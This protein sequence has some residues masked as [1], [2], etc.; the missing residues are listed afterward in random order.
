[1]KKSWRIFAVLLFASALFAGA[2]LGDRLLALTDD[3]RSNLKSYTELIDVAYERYGAEILYRDLVY[4]SI[5][6]MLRNLDPHT[7]FLSR[8]A[9]AQMRSRQQSSFYGLGI[10]VGLRNGRLTVITPIPGTPAYKLGMRAGDIISAINGE[11]TEE[12]NTDDA[13]SRLKGPKGTTV[14]VTLLRHGMDEPLELTVTRAEIPQNTVNYAYMIKPDTGYLSVRDF[15]KSTGSEV[16]RAL[17]E[18]KAQG[19]KKLIL[20]IRNNGG[21]LLDQGIE[22]ADQ[23]V[24][25]G[26][27]I[28]ETRGRIPSSYS[29]YFSSG[30]FDEFGVPLVVL[31]NGGSASASEI[32]SGAIQ[33]HDVGLVVGEPTWGKGLVQ[34]VYSL[35]NDAGLALTTARYYTPS[36]RLIQRDYT[37]YWDYYTQYDAEDSED[38]PDGDPSDRGEKKEI[39]Y[40]DLGREVYGGG[41]ITPDYRIDPGTLAPLLQK[42]LARSAYFTF[43]IEYSGDNEIESTS[44]APDEQVIAEL[45][46]F[47]VEREYADREEV[48]KAFEDPG[49]VEYTKYRLQLEIFNTVFSLEEGHRAFSNVDTQIQAAYDLFEEASELLERRKK[50]EAS[51]RPAPTGQVASLAS[52]GRP[53]GG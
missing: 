45:K 15:S 40:T 44:W 22:V 5:Q 20:D 18:L 17:R 7:S 35:P 25:H 26:G 43:A 9:Y 24:P 34:T 47:L 28:V 30:D 27:K 8:E 23:F 33:D 37:S 31:V 12:M 6:G 21:G 13:I 48:E 50:L 16:T 42:V 14:D 38:Q 41:G 46:D 32:L 4:G 39:F 52:A 53:I 51:D 10:F 3:V 11:P 19:M 49:V 36:G 1:M 2:F 29:S